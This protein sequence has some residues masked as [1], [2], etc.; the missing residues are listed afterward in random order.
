MPATAV[1]SANRNVHDRIENPTAGKIVTHQRPDND[2]AERQ[3][4]RGGQQRQTERQLKRMQDPGAGDDGHE[5][6]ERK[7]PL[8]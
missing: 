2:K 1:G 6:V 3:V 7:L 4:D 5:P 8:S